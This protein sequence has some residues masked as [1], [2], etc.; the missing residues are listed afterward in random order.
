MKIHK[1][2]LALPEMTS[3]E[4]EGLKKDL[5]E[6]GQ[7]VPIILYEGQVLDG[8]HRW[9]ALTSLKI[10]PKTTEFKGTEIE[11]AAKV[12]SLNFHRRHMTVGQRAMFTIDTMGASV[13]KA[14]KEKYDKTRVVTTNSK[15]LSKVQ[16]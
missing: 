16:R 3:E 8:R 4:Y 14:A 12:M 2:A 1:F 11:A 5:K 13:E 7:T 6:N 15:D 9:K 10:T